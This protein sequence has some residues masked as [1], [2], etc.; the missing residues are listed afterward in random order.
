[1][2]L[3]GG[4]EVV[5]EVC[6]LEALAHLLLLLG[7][8]FAEQLQTS[9]RVIPRP[10]NLAAHVDADRA[11]AHGP[12]VELRVLHIGLELLGVAGAQ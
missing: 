1:L 6:G 8:V 7:P 2:A 11:V 3:P 12:H 4:P 10:A 9:E 5:A